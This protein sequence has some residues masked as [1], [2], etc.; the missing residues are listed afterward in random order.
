MSK[1]VTQ[2]QPT[3]WLQTPK[4]IGLAHFLIDYGEEHD[5]IWVVADDATGEIWA[6]PN[7]DV[8]AIKNTSLG[9]ERSTKPRPVIGFKN[10][11]PMQKQSDPPMPGPE[12]V[13][14]WPF[15]P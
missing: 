13:L 14:Q 9:A 10:G 11:Q 1:S 6:W 15:V 2:L 3:I 4:G 7:P 5:L 8:R 12:S